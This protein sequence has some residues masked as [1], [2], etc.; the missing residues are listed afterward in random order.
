M[1][2]DQ[3]VFIQD[4]RFTLHHDPAGREWTLLI[5]YLQ[6]RD[7]GTYLCQVKIL[8]LQWASL[9]VNTEQLFVN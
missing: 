6:E 3:Q 4:K 2:A 9:I 5:K 8:K 7:E 1:S